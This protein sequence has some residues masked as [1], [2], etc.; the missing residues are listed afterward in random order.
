MTTS[1]LRLRRRTAVAFLLAALLA[2]VASG[3]VVVSASEP[4]T[5]RLQPGYN[6]VTWNGAEPYPIS[7]FA[8]TPITQIH[9]WDSTRQEWLGRFVGRGRREAAGVASAAARAIFDRRSGRL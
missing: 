2:L 3:A 9:R 4:A 6:A 7:D 8:D 1:Y 5:I